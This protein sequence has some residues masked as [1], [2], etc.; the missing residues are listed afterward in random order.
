MWYCK[1][2][3]YINHFVLNCLWI[4]N[5]LWK[6]KPV[7]ATSSEVPST[8]QL[9]TLATYKQV[10]SCAITIPPSLTSGTPLHPHDFALSR[11]V[12]SGSLTKLQV[13]YAD[14]PT[15]HPMISLSELSHFFCLQVC[16]PSISMC[17][18][19]R[20]A[21]YVGGKATQLLPPIQRHDSVI[22]DA[23]PTRSLSGR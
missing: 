6:I 2:Y 3:I 14:V 7:S 11:D 13:L 15:I 16:A 21:L 12:S 5:V 22:Q 17:R 8:A 18:Q 23:L 20:R 4:S 1:E 19:L 10:S 9:I